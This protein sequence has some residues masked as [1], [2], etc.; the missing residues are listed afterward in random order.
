MT[1]GDI[2]QL[3]VVGRV[4]GETHVHTLHFEYLTGTASEAGLAANWNAE[5][6]TNWRAIFG[7]DETPNLTVEARQVCGV[8]VLRAPSVEV[9]LNQAG[10]RA[11][12]G[13]EFAPS[14]L[15]MCVSEKTALAGKRYRGRFYV[16]GVWEADIDRNDFVTTAPP[17]NTHRNNVQAYVTDLIATYGPAG[18]NADYRLFVYSR[19]LSQLQPASACNT[20]G[21]RVTAMTLRPDICSMQSRRTGRGT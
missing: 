9:P 1:A 10:T 21:A 2:A 4:L 17:A 3:S 6:G 18:T 7:A 19:R 14:W 5:V 12:P 8:G 13:G 20:R 11:F 16:G 15:A